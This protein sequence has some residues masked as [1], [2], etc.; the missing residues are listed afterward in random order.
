MPFIELLA[1][2]LRNPL[3][4]GVS[5]LELGRDSELFEVTCSSVR[6]HNA[7]SSFIIAQVAQIDCRELHMRAESQWSSN[8]RVIGSAKFG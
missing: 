7:L 8:V 3:Y 6:R 2:F 5:C 4:K 1:T